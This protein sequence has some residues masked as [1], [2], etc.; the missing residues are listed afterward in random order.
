[1][2]YGSMLVQEQDNIKRVQLADS[3]LDGAVLAGSDGSSVPEQS[4]SLLA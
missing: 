1:M 3:Y 4:P 2:Q